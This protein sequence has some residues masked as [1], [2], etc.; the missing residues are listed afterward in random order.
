MKRN[1]T[2]NLLTTLSNE[3]RLR[4]GTWN[5]KTLYQA[6]KLAQAS[7]I[8]ERYKLAF[9][10]ISEMRWN[11][12]GQLVTPKGHVVLWSGMPNENDIHQHGVGLLINARIRNAVLNY[13]FI[14]ERMI[15]VRFQCKARNLSVI[16]CYA[17]TEDADD[18][19]KQQFY[20]QLNK[21]IADTPKSDMKVVMGDFNAKVGANNED[22][23]HVIGKHGVGVM[24]NNGELL[25]ELCGLNQLKIGGTLFPHKE[26]HKVTWVS[27][28][29]R[30]QNQID[31]ICVSA[32]WSNTLCDVRNKRGADIASDHHLVVGALRI[33]LKNVPN[34]HKC[35]RVKYKIARLKSTEQRAAFSQTLRSKLASK[36]SNANPNTEERWQKFKKAVEETCM[37][38]LGKANGS[39][40]DFIS[41]ETWNLIDSRTKLK[42]QINSTLN[43]NERKALQTKY[44]MIDKRVRREV[45]C[46]KKEFINS[47]AKKAETAAATHNMKGLYDITKRIAGT[48]AKRSVPVKSKDGELLTNVT[49][50]LN[51]WKEHFAEV[52]NLTRD[53]VSV[54]IRSDNV[55]LLPIR[56]DPPSRNET[57]NAI[58]S[59]KSG[60]AAGVDNITAEVL[61]AD[62]NTV[63]EQFHELFL[64]IWENESYPQDWLEGIIVKLPKKGDLKDCNNWRGINILCV[65]LKVFMMIILE[66]MVKAVDAKI[67]SEQAGFRE[68]RSCTDQINTIR[69]IIE[70]SV[71]MNSPL[72]LLFIDFEKAFDSIDRECI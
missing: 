32:K 18:T 9:M 34:K 27:P 44:N 68:G 60:K 63:A 52:L 48:A 16:Q 29:S 24:N 61:Q 14:N 62:V 49:E 47:L 38:R 2:G 40:G 23:E 25:V 54:T 65:A 57:I 71:E 42:N 59:L 13:K 11:E 35:P 67:R 1:R 17:P 19:T 64:H 8:L 69:I 10:G 58:K 55:K 4:F 39:R 3:N 45:R 51:R 41:Q 28:D 7:K 5:V 37:E 72:Y 36:D 21:T 15:F 20:D 66:R 33:S 56:T 30:T 70:Q 6:G 12:C 50:Q 26:N 22:L 31:H 46:D 53:G 43:V